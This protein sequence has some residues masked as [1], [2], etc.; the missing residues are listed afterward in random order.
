MYVNPGKCPF[1]QWVCWIVVMFGSHLTAM[2]TVVLGRTV[3]LEGS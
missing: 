2:Q 3:D 1:F